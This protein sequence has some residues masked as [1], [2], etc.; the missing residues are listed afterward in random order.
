MSGNL[1]LLGVG[2]GGDACASTQ[3]HEEYS[4]NTCLGSAAALN[5]ISGCV[6]ASGVDNSTGAAPRA[7]AAARPSAQG[8]VLGSMLTRR[9]RSCGA[10]RRRP[11]PM[12]TVRATP[13]QVR[14]L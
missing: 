13:S 1:N 6:P 12:R 14:H 9:V 11:I 7:R 4:N 5:D 10:P 3:A 2:G 8:V